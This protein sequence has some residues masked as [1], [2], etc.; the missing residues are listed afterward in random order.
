MNALQSAPHFHIPHTR[1][2]PKS[3]ITLVEG[4]VPE[5]ASLLP[6]DLWGVWLQVE[7]A[8]ETVARVMRDLGSF[9]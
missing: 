4:D 8:E 1:Q 6:V 7:D 9:G 3:R 5:T 2:D